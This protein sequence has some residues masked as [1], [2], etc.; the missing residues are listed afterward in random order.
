MK[1]EDYTQ[2]DAFQAE[3]RTIFA[4]EWLPICAE[5]Q[6]AGPGDFLSASV[7]GWGVLAVR[8]KA[9]T[10]RVMR[11][12]CRHQNMP[13]TSTPSGQCE[14]FRC[15][16][17]GWTYGLDGKLLSAPPPV[18]PADPN[19]PDVNLLSFA[20]AKAGGLLFFSLA[21]PTIPPTLGPLPA[22]GGT[23]ATDVSANWKSCAEHL[24][25]TDV[26]WHWPLLALRREGAVAIVQ[27][28]VPHTF[29]RTRL[30]THVFGA[31]VDAYRD[32]AA[33]TKQACERLQAD[34]ATGTMADAAN[35][36]VAAFHHRLDAC[37][38]E[39]ASAT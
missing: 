13:V 19:S 3:K 1:S 30:F 22:Y 10:V 23:I 29:P 37:Y 35:D 16:F 33:S 20:T 12:A 36:L 14:T 9:G 25:G 5:A 28:I 38:L 24:L 21:N 32:E 31:A 26:A 7:G 4:T 11:N 2:G 17:H 8:D 15:R 39:A 27:Q 6:I 18:A 34:R